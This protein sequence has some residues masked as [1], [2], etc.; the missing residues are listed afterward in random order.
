VPSRNTDKKDAYIHQEV[1]FMWATGNSFAFLNFSLSLLL[2]V[3]IRSAMPQRG[4]NTPPGNLAPS[5]VFPSIGVIGIAN[6]SL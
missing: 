4:Q 2:E 6:F 1:A 5:G 3:L